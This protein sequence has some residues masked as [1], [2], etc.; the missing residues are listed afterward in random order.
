M[1]KQNFNKYDALFFSPHID[2]AIFSCGGL[3]LKLLKKKRK[4]AVV[5]IFTKANDH[6]L[7]TG[8]IKKELKKYNFKSAKKLY[9]S[10]KRSEKEIAKKI[11]I[12]VF[13][14]DFEDGLFRK[15]KDEFLYPNYECLFSGKINKDEKD[16]F[17]KIKAKVL[18]YI[19]NCNKKTEIY[20]PLGVGKHIDHIITKKVV[21]KLGKNLNTFLWEDV[22]YSNN[23]G[24][25]EQTLNLSPNK[26]ITLTDLEAK[27]KK[28]LC[29]MYKTQFIP[30]SKTSFSSINFYKEVIYK[31]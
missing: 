21:K 5:N 22:P 2:D 6:K 27:Q 13:F 20:L 8:S 3:I 30:S 24:Q 14:L 4:I 1:S 18:P 29:K 19:E 26:I 25:K 10:R 23:I 7:K 17:E 28:Q 31:S 9:S 16:I 12:D 15:N 11:N